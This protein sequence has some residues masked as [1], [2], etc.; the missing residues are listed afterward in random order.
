MCLTG[1]QGLFD[2]FVARCWISLCES[3]KIIR[4]FQGFFLVFCRK[5]LLTNPENYDKIN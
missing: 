4:R 5:N 1:G 3:T 2:G